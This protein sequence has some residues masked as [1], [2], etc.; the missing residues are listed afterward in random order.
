M[1]RKS[2]SI[3]LVLMLFIAPLQSQKL[4]ILHTN[5]LHSRLLGF[6]PNADYTPETTGDDATVGGFARLATLIRNEKAA[7]PDEVLVF[8]GGDF[9]MGT[10]FHTLEPTT[11]FQLKLMHRMGY[12]AVAIGNHE[13]DMGIGTLG[14]ILAR[15][16]M[17][18]DI[19]QMLLSNIQL[20]QEDP[21][22]DL[23]ESLTRRGVVQ[24]YT[25]LEKNGLKV[26]VFALMG[27][28][29]RLVAPYVKP[30][31][32]TDPLEKA[33]EMVDLLRNREK[34]DLVICLSH[35][36]LKLNKNGDWAGEDYDMASRVP[37]IDL[38]VSGHSHSKVKEPLQVGNTI[39]VQ[40]GSEG[41]FLGKVEIEKT[42]AGTRLIAAQLIPVNDEIHGDREIQGMIEVQ[43]ELI[44]ERVLSPY[45]FLIDEPLVE[46]SFDLNFNEQGDLSL[47]E[48]GPLLADALYWYARTIDAEGTD[49]VLVPGGIIRDNLIAGSNGVQ[50]PADI[51]RV[52]PL[53]SGVRENTPGYSMTKIYLTGREIKNILEVMMLA[54]RMSTGNYPYWSGVK[55]K[56]NTLRMPLD[57]IY[58]VA[59]GNEES[60]YET[61][62]LNKDESSLYGIVTNA[63]VLEFFGIIREITKGT[64][65]VEPKFS[66]G[67]PIPD[68]KLP[69]IDRDPMTDGLQE[70]KEWVG[71]MK[72]LQQLPDTDGNGIPNIPEKYRTPVPYAVGKASLSPVKLVK[73]SN[74]ITL[75][76]G[77][78]LGG[79]AAATVILVL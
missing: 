4:T 5:D 51:F 45:G 14:D 40:T 79:I 73:G 16:A 74:G 61:I 11:G 7:H 52:M 77:L 1:I 59:L 71:L 2:L 28:E 15:S 26:G 57:Q 19:P 8:D 31:T 47:S 55:F 43:M 12:D 3:S 46:T 9:L 48:L 68:L 6:A 24:P 58:E 42:E 53:G 27:Y 44:E 29:A 37:G 64:L 49:M 78:L 35:S 66:D 39:I 20:N 32:I 36:G 60:G 50:L 72:Y 69:L 38:I 25:I 62:R 56:Y 34:C 54:P 30:A 21:E 67:T 13:F 18:G 76:P 23:F 22:D 41:R 17:G 63:Y 33:A 70:A 65:K 75:V 10:L